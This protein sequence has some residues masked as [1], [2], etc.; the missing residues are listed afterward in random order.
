MVLNHNNYQGGEYRIHGRSLSKGQLTGRLVRSEKKR[1][2][3]AGDGSDA[4]VD[5]DPWEG[6]S[7]GGWEVIQ[8]AS[9]KRNVRNYV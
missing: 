8:R 9:L 4:S 6:T 2:Q 5:D 7:T 3:S 1:E